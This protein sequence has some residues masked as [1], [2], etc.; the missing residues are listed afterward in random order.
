MWFKRKIVVD[1][2]TSQDH[3]YVWIQPSR[4]GKFFGRKPEVKMFLNG[5]YG[6]FGR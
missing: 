4:L 1:I 6:K 5:T 3:I 2:E